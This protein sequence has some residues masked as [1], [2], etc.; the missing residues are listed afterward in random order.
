[1][2]LRVRQV[3]SLVAL[4]A[5]VA[6]AAWVRPCLDDD[7]CERDFSTA[8]AFSCP[9]SDQHHDPAAPI[10]SCD[11]MCHVPGIAQGAG[12]ASTRLFPPADLDPVAVRDALSSGY[13]DS[14]FRPPRV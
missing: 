2:S 14:L 12:P 11:C 7:D 1:M 4:L 10:D 8:A 6:G 3:A 5:F 13:L 9:A